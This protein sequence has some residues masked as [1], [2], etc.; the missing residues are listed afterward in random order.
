MD[1][2][3]SD[4]NIFIDLLSVDLIEDFF[5]LPVNIHTIDYVLHELK[6]EQRNV[7]SKYNLTVKEYSDADHRKILD[8]RSGCKGN[9]SFT[10]CAVCFYA[11]TNNYRLLTGDK[12][13]RNAAI[14][15]GVTVCG[16]LF[17]FDELVKHGILTQSFAA[18]KL[19]QLIRINN[20]LPKKEIVERI[21]KWSD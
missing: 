8:F 9:V 10:D 18:D 1:V 16:I 2:V 11:K 6:E 14:I 19:A 12:A 13:L 20:R 4:T 21:A 3:V 5:R 7:L 15:D 17:I